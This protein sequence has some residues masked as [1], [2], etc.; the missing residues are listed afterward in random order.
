MDCLVSVVWAVPGREEEPDSS[1][2]VTTCHSVIVS[3]NILLNAGCSQ[4]SHDQT[5]VTVSIV[6]LSYF[7]N[8]R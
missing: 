4:L 3:S 5:C 2:A 6:T 8:V 7:K 1:L